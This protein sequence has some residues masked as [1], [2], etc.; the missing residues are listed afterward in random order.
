V[1]VTARID[2]ALRAC[3]ELAA[4][5][6]EGPMKSEVLS[7]KQAIPRNYL[8][9]ILVD[10]RRS[11][12]VASQRGADGGYW[13]K[14]EPAKVTL[15]DVVRAVD[16][17][18]ANVRGE[19]PDA[20]VYEGPAAPLTSVWVAVRA[21]L[22]SVLEEVTLADLVAGGELPKAVQALVDDPKA[23]TSRWA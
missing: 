4:V 5:H 15:A 22:R 23:W 10:L 20:L 3:A 2:Y 9:A 1:Q 12:I 14:P 19:L 8:E 13:L 16:G 17:P 21:A 11:G 6:G 7:S 18:L